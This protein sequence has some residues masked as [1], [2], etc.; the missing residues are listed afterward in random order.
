MHA[1]H[2]TRTL[3]NTLILS[4]YIPSALFAI[5]QGLL[6]PIL[7]VY[8]LNFGVSYTLVGLVL[9]GE[10]IGMLFSDIPAG[11]L[12]RRFDHK[13]VMIMGLASLAV[14]VISLF[15]TT[16]IY[17]VLLFRL[18]A[19]FGAALFSVSR[20]AYLAEVSRVGNRGR[21]I[22]VFGGIMRVGK[23]IGPAASGVI[24]STLN[25]KVPFILVGVACIIALAFVFIFTPSSE[26]FIN[27]PTE[28]IEKKNHLW[29][30]IKSQYKVL[31]SAGSGQFF[32]QMIRQAKLVIIPLYASQELGLDVQAIGLI[33]SVAQAFDVL[34]FYPAGVIMD[35]WGRK[36]AII[37][38][39]L[40]QAIGMVLIPLTTGFPGLLF[41]SCV[42]AF[43]NGLS[44]GTMLTMG[45]DL[46]PENARGEFLG[47]WRLIGDSGITGAPLIVGGIAQILVL[48]AAAI[49]MSVPGF[50]T[51]LVYIFFVPE[52]L[53]KPLPAAPDS[54]R[55]GTTT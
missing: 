30:T 48:P 41:V 40:I 53:K 43:G 16:T 37:P 3:L 36:Y 44:S 55:Q 5:S 32:A 12:L 2:S 29:N 35:R 51:A 15:F 22:S 20:H 6:I 42:I 47:L 9:A 4:F 19:G 38:S 21:V 49:A 26:S 10:G 14:S 8:L 31:L 45:A 34:L 33:M 54:C 11:M 28:D 52:T 17:S 39:F 18:S 25:I 27:T 13:W 1:R 50:I 46:A 7:P 24:A 23:F